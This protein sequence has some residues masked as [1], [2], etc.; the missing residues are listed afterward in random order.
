MAVN[1]EGEMTEESQGFPNIIEL[2]VGGRHFSTTHLTLT[3]HQDTM[4]GTMFSGKFPCIHDKDGRY[5]IDADG[6]SFEH[7]LRYLRLNE[8][9]PVSLM[10]KVYKDAVYFGLNDLIHELELQPSI[11]A[12]LMRDKFYSRLDGFPGALNEILHQAGNP[13]IMHKS[14]PSTT[15]VVSALELEHKPKSEE[16]DVNHVCVCAKSTKEADVKLKPW[17]QFAE[18]GAEEYV[19]ALKSNLEE[20]GFVVVYHHIGN[21]SYSCTLPPQGRSSSH[22]KQNCA[23]LFFALVFHWTKM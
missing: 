18:V 6:E 11:M 8:L 7:I 1:V 10:E 2:N 21:C 16:F 5:F 15:V 23:T 19:R 14:Y 3:K 20:R 22:R 4:L 13:E 12:K 9:P 17:K